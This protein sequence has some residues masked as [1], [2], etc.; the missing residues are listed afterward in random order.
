[1]TIKHSGGFMKK[2]V[3]TLLA[4]LI[5]AGQV[6][7]F[8]ITPSMNTITGTATLSGPVVL[9]ETLGAELAGTTCAEYTYAGATTCTDA[10][11]TFTRTASAANLT[12]TQ[13]TQTIAVGTQYRVSFTDTITASTITPTLGGIAGTVESASGSPVAYA[14]AITTGKLIFTFTATSAGTITLPSVKEVTSVISSGSTA[15][16]LI[17]RN[18]THAT[19]VEEGVIIDVIGTKAAGTMRGLTIEDNGSGGTR[20]GLVYRVAG[21]SKLSVTSAGVLAVSSQVATPNI[22]PSAQA[23]PLVLNNNNIINNMTAV[24]IASGTNN[25]VTGSTIAASITPTYN[26]LSGDA[27]NI[28]FLIKRVE[29]A[30]GSGPQKFMSLKSGAAGA[31]EV[32]NITNKGHVNTGTGSAAPALTACGTD[33]TIVTG[34]NDRAGT[35]T[36]GDTGTGCVITFATAYTNTPACNVTAQTASNLTSMTKTNTAITIVGLPGVFDY[37]CSGL[38]E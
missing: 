30:L 11:L 12:I 8:E 28:D 17:K 36:M 32:F 1:M 13:T 38:N 24:T 35:F 3:L 7:A 25:L 16:V 37:H 19:S 14:T 20:Y 2:T 22:T 18:L 10:P 15:P 9:G 5:L 6:W 4:V 34:S 21:A 23:T 31:T 29:T 33:P 26:Q 27:D